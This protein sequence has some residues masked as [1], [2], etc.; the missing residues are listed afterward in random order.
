MKRNENETI[1]NNFH[2]LHTTTL[3]V[4]RIN[5]CFNLILE[6]VIRIIRR[7]EEI[8]FDKYANIM[9][10]PESVLSGNHNDEYIKKELHKI[11]LFMRCL[12]DLVVNKPEIIGY[13]L[14]EICKNTIKLN[15]DLGGLCNHWISPLLSALRGSLRPSTQLFNPQ[16]VQITFL[17]EPCYELGK[18]SIYDLKNIITK[19]ILDNEKKYTLND[20]NPIYIDGIR[21]FL[22]IYI[23][24]LSS[25]L[26]DIVEEYWVNKL[27]KLINKKTSTLEV[28]PE[29]LEFTEKVL[30][31]CKNFYM[32]INKEF[33]EFECKG[34]SEKNNIIPLIY[35]YLSTK[36]I[37][38]LADTINGIYTRLFDIGGFTNPNTFAKF[39]IYPF[40]EI[41]D[42]FCKKLIINNKD[43]K[44]KL[45]KYFSNCNNKRLSDL[46]WDKGI[47]NYISIYDKPSYI[48][49]FVPEKYD[50][51]WISVK[52]KLSVKNKKILEKWVDYFQKFVF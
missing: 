48:C 51:E 38:S 35:Y 50:I 9:K 39:F 4:T 2:L 34:A 17:T 24:P 40:Y 18:K 26:N 32:K 27:P 33:E 13:M 30:Q 1:D 5:S 21:D 15:K 45:Y 41:Y 28:T 7:Y 23:Y 31:F 36:I 46:V 6:E 11:W 10:I 49:E 20:L 42:D 29:I 25:I 3:P 16:S 14:G 8:E 43:N 37:G 22:G 44:F 12:M 47:A 52:N 19:F